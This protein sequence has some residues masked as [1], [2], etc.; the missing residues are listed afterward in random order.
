MLKNFE[1]NPNYF[2]E[3]N[4]FRRIIC[5]KDYYESL[6]YFLNNIDY[7]LANSKEMFFKHQPRETTTVGIV[8]IANYKLVVKRYNFRNFWHGLKLRL[9]ASKAMRSWLFSH[10]LQAN[11][12][13]TANPV[14]VVEERIG[15]LRGRAYYIAEY[16]PGTRGCEYFSDQ[17]TSQATWQ[18]TISEIEILTLRL[19]ELGFSHADYH[20]G[21]LVIKDK[22][23]YLIDLDNMKQTQP[24]SGKFKRRHQKDIEN[25]RW[26]LHKNSLADKAFKQYQQHRIF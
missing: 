20:F 23:P 26:Y 11:D 13:A 7:Y 1:K 17:S 14:A 6:A 21:N 10:R 24:E 15:P 12:I 8:S 22:K 19:R 3:K 16:V 25:F 2:S 4:F 9:R 5:K 18:D